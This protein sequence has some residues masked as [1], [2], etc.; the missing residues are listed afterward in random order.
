[1][2]HCLYFAMH[3]AISSLGSYAVDPSWIGGCAMDCTVCRCRCRHFKAHSYAAA[4]AL[5]GD[6]SKEEGGVPWT[7]VRVG[8]RDEVGTVLRLAAALDRVS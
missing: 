3:A 4:Q 6:V 7:G 8:G 5:G 2:S 1:M